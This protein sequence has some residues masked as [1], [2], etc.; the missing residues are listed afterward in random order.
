MIYLASPYSH[1][2]PAVREARFLKVCRCAAAMVGRR[3]HV[4]SPIVHSHPI[5]VRHGL[6]GD[7]WFWRAWN[8]DMLQR[9]NGL[10][11]FTIDGWT[12]SVGVKD[13]I[14]FAR[15]LGMPVLFVDPKTL[16]ATVDDPRSGS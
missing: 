15:K 2:D 8:R 16:A 7:F 4:F 6:P 5:A 10:H 1:P 3:N 9:C 12:E 14:E 13:E 11:V